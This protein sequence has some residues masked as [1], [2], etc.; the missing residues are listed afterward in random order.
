[1]GWTAVG[2]AATQGAGAE[3]GTVRQR[4][5]LLL[6]APTPLYWAFRRWA[7]CLEMCQDVRGANSV[8]MN[9]HLWVQRGGCPVR[10]LGL[11]H[12]YKVVHEAGPI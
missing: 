11:L 2:V 8:I 12:S 10:R 1:M 9:H 4:P 3:A 7:W 6:S 5:G